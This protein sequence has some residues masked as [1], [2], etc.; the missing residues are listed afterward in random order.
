MLIGCS[1]GQA[2]FRTVQIC[3]AGP[4]E[5]PAFVS[6]MDQIAQ[7]NQMTFTN[8][9]GATEAELRSIGNA[10]VPVAHPHV[11]IGADRSGDF[12]FGAGNLSLPTR[13]IAIGFN[14]SKPDIARQFA[15]R[16]VAEVATRWRIYEVPDGQG[17]LPLR[18]CK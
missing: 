6:L 18:D 9:S 7:A 4:E 15:T 10:N 11:N 2:S 14:G 12:S 3:L 13:Q 8:R 17:A 5:V 1:S 16:L